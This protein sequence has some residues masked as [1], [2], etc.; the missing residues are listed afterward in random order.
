MARIQYKDSN[1]KFINPY[2][3]VGVNWSKNNVKKEALETGNLSG[4]LK[5]KL[6]TRTP[7]AI[8]DT[9][10]GVTEDDKNHRSYK[11]MSDASGK[12][13]IPGSSL[14][15]AIRSVYETVTDSCLATADPKQFISRRA[16]MRECGKPYLLCHEN[17]AYKLYEA[18]SYLIIIKDDKY[19]ELSTTDQYSPNAKAISGC[20][21]YTLPELREYG[22]GSIVD[23]SISDNEE[24]RSSSGFKMGKV[25]KQLGE[26][27]GSRKGYLYIGE[28]LPRDNNKLQS[29]KHFERIFEKKKEFILIDEIKVKQLEELY[30][31]YNDPSVNT[32]VKDHNWYQGFDKAFKAMKNEEGMLPVWYDKAKGKISLASIGRIFY[33]KNMDDLLGEKKPC[34]PEN[35]NGKRKNLCRACSLFGTEK[36]EGRLASRVRISDASSVSEVEK[37]TVTLKELGS[38]KISYYRFYATNDYDNKGASLRGRKIYWHNEDEQGFLTCIKTERNATMEIVGGDKSAEFEFSVYY[39]NLTEKELEELKWVLTL[40]DNREDS[41]LCHKLG[42][43]KPIGLGSSKI[44]ITSEITRRFKIET[45]EYKVDP[46]TPSVKDKSDLDFDMDMVNELL[47][48]LNVAQTKGIKVSYPYVTDHKEGDNKNDTAA[49]KWFSDKKDKDCWLTIDDIAAGKRMNAISIDENGN[50]NDRGNHSKGKYSS[51]NKGT[52]ERFSNKMN[53]PIDI[54]NSVKK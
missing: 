42:H 13:F 15:G 44:V 31:S 24:F 36:G 53:I 37:K 49:H 40:G 21:S 38:P 10:E 6:I 11:F 41:D 29:K 23:F 54:I 28:V 30:K 16:G 50:Y 2:N 48:I 14:R 43:G 32:N 35:D 51:S 5:C 3:F 46:K 9:N 26:S 17:G 33:D 7:L 34:T 20:K 25:V 12:P 19:R 27:E 45:G 22:Y 8:P 47:K 18:T 39:D 4:E 1:E 52:G